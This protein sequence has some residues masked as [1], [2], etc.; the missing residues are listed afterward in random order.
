MNGK[1]VGLAWVSQDLAAPGQVLTMPLRG[2]LA[3][4]EI[5]PDPFYDPAGQETESLMTATIQPVK[6][7][8]PLPHEPGAGRDADRP[9]RLAS[10]GPLSPP[11]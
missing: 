9:R 1:A 8:P 7:P 10:R 11:G 2:R 4:A 3:Q 5:V 6:A